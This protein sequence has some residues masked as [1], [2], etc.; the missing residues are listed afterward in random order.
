MKSYIDDNACHLFGQ[1][2][3]RNIY[4]TKPSHCS[5]QISR[6]LIRGAKSIHSFSLYFQKVD[7]S[8]HRFFNY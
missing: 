5:E 7:A 3:I 2:Q 8:Y 6:G 1:K 4:L